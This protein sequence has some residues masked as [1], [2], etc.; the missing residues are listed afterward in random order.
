MCNYQMRNYKLIRVLVFCIALNVMATSTFRTFSV[1]GIVKQLNNRGN[2]IANALAS[3]N[4]MPPLDFSLRKG[5]MGRIG[6]LGGC[7]DY[8]G[9]PFYAASSALKV[10]PS[11]P[12]ILLIFIYKYFYVVWR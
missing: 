6:I 9:A 10:V 4:F 5:Q 3:F 12:T 2:C 7:R 8:T 1:K 11:C